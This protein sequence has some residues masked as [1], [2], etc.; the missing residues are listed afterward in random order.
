MFLYI[1]AINQL[2]S[3]LGS[4]TIQMK[5][6]I[7]HYKAR[8]VV[9][10]FPREIRRSLGKALRE[11][12]TGEKLGMPLSRPMSAVGIGVSELRIKDSS[13]AFRVFYL[14]KSIRGILVFHAF[15]K[16][17]QKTPLREIELGRKHL[18]EM[19]HEKS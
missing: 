18:R 15:R 4:E 6:I 14:T 17:S 8:E 2:T 10:S 5:E 19:L 7:F 11:L 3:R 16:K 12:Q 13:G 9:Q 1:F